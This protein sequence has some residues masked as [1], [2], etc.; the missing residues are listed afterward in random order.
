MHACQ[1]KLPKYKTLLC[2]HVFAHVHFQS[3]QIKSILYHACY[4]ANMCQI[5]SCMHANRKLPKYTTF[6]CMHIFMHVRVLVCPSNSPAMFVSGPHVIL[7][8]HVQTW[9]QGGAM[10]TLPIPSA[11][12]GSWA[13]VGLRHP[14]AL[15][16]GGPGAAIRRPRSHC[17]A[18]LSASVPTKAPQGRLTLAALCRHDRASPCR[19]ISLTIPPHELSLKRHHWPLGRQTSRPFAQTKR[20]TTVATA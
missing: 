8:L 15:Q 4:Q 6:P 18:H 14:I 2:M 10:V 5:Y 12:K 11:G 13:W 9:L 16:D 1:Q 3:M 17:T 20:V 7:S 19:K